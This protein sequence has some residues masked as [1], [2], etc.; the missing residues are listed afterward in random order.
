VGVVTYWNGEPCKAKRVEVTVAN[1][2]DLAKY[3]A[4]D[5]VGKRWPAVAIIYQSKM[6]FIDNENDDGWTK[7]TLGFG[8]PMFQHK[9]IWV[10][11]G[12]AVSVDQ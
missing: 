7:I 2:H 10:E 5:L 4:R 12:S 9:G 1:P 11:D 3:W 6:F 8:H